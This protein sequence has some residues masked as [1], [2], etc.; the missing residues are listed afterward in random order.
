MPNMFLPMIQQ[1]QQG[2][3]PGGRRPNAVPMQQ[4]PQPVPVMQ[5]QVCGTF[6]FYLFRLVT[7]F[8]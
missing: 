4:G 3:R 2:P 5:Q 1:G 8:P 6:G 7:F